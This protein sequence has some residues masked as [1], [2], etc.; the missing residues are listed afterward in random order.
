V[1]GAAFPLGRSARTSCQKWIRQITG[2]T[3]A[4]LLLLGC[5]APP[6]TPVSEAPAATTTLVTRRTSVEEIVGTWQ[7][8]IGP[9]Y[10]RFYE[11]CTFH[12]ADAQES[13]DSQPLATNSYQFEGTEV[14]M[15]EVSVSGVPSCGESIGTYEI[16][17]LESGSI[18]LV[19]LEDDAATERVVS[20]ESMKQS[21][22]V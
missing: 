13:V 19:V 4:I 20:Q 12:E 9:G 18:R 7:K 6:A 22:S 1:L 3:L 17:L 14:V 16:R 5:G 10:I 15:K 21:P 2:V 8:T 11:D